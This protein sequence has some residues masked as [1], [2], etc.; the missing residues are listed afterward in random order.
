MSS[1]KYTVNEPAPRDAFRRI[2]ASLQSEH[3]CCEIL[4]SEHC[5]HRYVGVKEER[6]Y[7]P[8][9]SEEERTLVR[10]VR[11]SRAGIR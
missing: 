1:V 5:V 2:S 7:T 6:P 8:L 4:V 3:V 11:A 9:R 10:P